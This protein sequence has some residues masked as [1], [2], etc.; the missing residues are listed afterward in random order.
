MKYLTKKNSEKIN[1]YRF[2]FVMCSVC[3]VYENSNL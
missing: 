1:Y 3:I 2:S